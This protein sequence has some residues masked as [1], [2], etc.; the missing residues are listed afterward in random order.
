M[1]RLG[2]QPPRHSFSAAREIRCSRPLLWPKL[3]RLCLAL[4]VGNDMSALRIR[5]LF[6]GRVKPY[7]RELD[8]FLTA[9]PNPTTRPDL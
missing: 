2:Q 8:Q 1:K 4:V 6:I 9:G 3:Q 5:A 7:L